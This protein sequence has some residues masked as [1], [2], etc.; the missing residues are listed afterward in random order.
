[1]LAAGDPLRIFRRHVVPKARLRQD[2]GAADAG[3]I[4]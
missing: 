3:C 1:M 4:G 2:A